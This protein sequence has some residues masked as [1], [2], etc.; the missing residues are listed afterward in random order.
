[1]PISRGD[2]HGHIFLPDSFRPIDRAVGGSNAALAQ[3]LY[4]LARQDVVWGPDIDPDFVGASINTNIW[5]TNAGTG[6]T[7]FAVPATPIVGGA[8][9]GATGTNATAANRRVNLYGAPVLAGDNN[10]CLEVRLR[11][12]ANTSLELEIGFI[13]TM[14][15]LASSIEA[16]VTDPDGTLTFAAGVGDAAIIGL[17]T[18]ETNATLLLACLGSGSLNAGSRDVFVGTTLPTS[19]DWDTY[20]MVLAGNTVAAYV[21]G[22]LLATRASA[23]EGGTLVRPFIFAG[24][25]TTTSRDIDIDRIDFW[26]DRA[27]R[28]A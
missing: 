5:T 16:V 26:Q 6:A 20:R 27:A 9:R 28:V 14:T 8:I 22:V 15:N 12:S 17:Y 2:A 10:A 7:A 1:M 21:N 11:A 18:D 13:D 24:G 4:R 25:V 19:N 23:I 3:L